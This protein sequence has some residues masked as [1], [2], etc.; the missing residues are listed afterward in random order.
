MAR[1]AKS[2]P[3]KETKPHVVF[4]SRSKSRGDL[5]EWLATEQDDAYEIVSHHKPRK[6]QAECFDKLKDE[7]F[8][9]INAPTGTGKS[10]MISYLVAHKLKK[11]P[12]LKAIIVVPQTIIASGFMNSV[13]LSLPDGTTVEWKPGLF[14]CDP[15][16]SV[17]NKTEALLEWLKLSAHAKT[18]LSQRIAVVCNQTYVRTFASMSDDVTYELNRNLLVV[19]DEAHHIYANLAEDSSNEI[20]KICLNHIK[21][22]KWNNHM[23]LVTATFF[24]NLQQSV[25][26]PDIIERFFEMYRLPFD[27]YFHSMMHFKSFSY[28]FSLFTNNYIDN[29]VSAVSDINKKK[30]ADK[31]ETAKCVVYLPSVNGRIAE[32]N[33]DSSGNKM[34]KYDVVKEIIDKIKIASGAM[35]HY[36]DP[37][38]VV[39]LCD[40]EFDKVNWV[41]EKDEKGLPTKSYIIND[42]NIDYKILDLVTEDAS[43][44]NTV[45]REARKSYLQSANRRK[46]CFDLIITLNM[47]KEGMDI[48]FADSEIIVG[49][50][51]SLNDLVQIVGRLFRDE[52]DWQSDSAKHRLGLFHKDHGRLPI[53]RPHG[54][55]F[56]TDVLGEFELVHLLKKDQV[57]IVHLLQH[58]VGSRTDEEMQQNFSDYFKNLSMALL[59]ESVLNPVFLIETAP[60]GT[61]TRVNPFV[62]L[63]IEPDVQL[64]IVHGIQETLLQ[65]E[66]KRG[67]SEYIDPEEDTDVLIKQLESVVSDQL[68]AE[69]RKTITPDDL[70]SIVRIVMVK[71]SRNHRDRTED[72]EEQDGTH[73]YV[74]DAID[75]SEIDFDKV[76]L[77]DSILWVKHF[78]TTQIGKDDLNE[79]RRLVKV[80]DSLNFHEWFAI[81]LKIRDKIIK[82]EEEKKDEKP[83][84]RAKGKKEI[85]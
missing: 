53:D 68:P 58:V 63:S 50:K 60:D 83:K 18:P 52:R 71:L 9:I 14:L 16:K 56:A 48:P 5:G 79:L 30:L 21:L 49:A 7:Q 47:V 78:A 64:S 62:K 34:S 36:V 55:K 73:L 32:N 67:T 8:A 85:R 54:Q 65:N 15:E 31:G 57:R 70:R 76:M 41:L 17:D 19:Y 37:H 81:A 20:G 59:M 12:S 77:M 27:V 6:W 4:R 46:S 29:I 3:A 22:G 26:P 44:F 82:E 74:D 23:L 11:N 72:E 38:G 39:H 45:D 40:K 75:S 25:L 51:G 1:K 84:G 35:H 24:R 10:T 80:R 13:L 66:C 28:E 42:G 61:K 69:I 2:T 43:G 33:L